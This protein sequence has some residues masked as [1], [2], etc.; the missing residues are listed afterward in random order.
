MNFIRD[1]VNLAVAK[2]REGK[3]KEAIQLYEKA[4]QIDS[5]EAIIYT[6]LAKS[7]YLNNQREDSLNNYITGLGISIISYANENG[8]SKSNIRN[9][10]M[11]RELVSSFFSTTGHLAHAYID[12]DKEC[13]ESLVDSLTQARSSLSRKQIQQIVNYEISNYRFGLAGGGIENEPEYHGIAHDLSFFEIY[14]HYGEGLAMHY[15]NWDS[16]S[17]SLRY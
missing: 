17:N 12:L 9:D 8:Y 5:E 14:K 16:I 6:S 13:I 4:L 11:R 7:Q 10:N 15:L 1:I 2:K 3:F